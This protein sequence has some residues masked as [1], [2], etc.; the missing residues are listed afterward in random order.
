MKRND[1]GNISIHSHAGY[2]V[3]CCREKFPGTYLCYYTTLGEVDLVSGLRLY[4][5]FSDLLPPSLVSPPLASPPSPRY[6][7]MVISL[8][9]EMGLLALKKSSKRICK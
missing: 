4:K 8:W 2:S 5:A 9:L 1:V 6:V 3:W 7:W